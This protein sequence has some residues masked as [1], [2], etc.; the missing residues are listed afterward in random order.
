[1]GKVTR[2]RHTAEFKARVALQAIKG[3]A[4]NGGD[5]CQA[6]RLSD[7]GGELET[8][9]DRRDGTTIATK[10]AAPATGASTAEVSKL[11]ANIGELIM[12]R[13]F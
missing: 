7:A 10:S 13:D 8:G 11:H 9:C 6:W 5:R 4:E 1:M 2:K 12:E 3:R